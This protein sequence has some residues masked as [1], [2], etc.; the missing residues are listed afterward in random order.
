MKNIRFINETLSHLGFGR[1]QTE[2]YLGLLKTGPATITDLARALNTSRQALYLLLPDLLDRGLVKEVKQ[3]KRPYYQALAPSQLLTL[4]EDLKTRVEEIVPSL[5]NIQA[6]PAE[7]PLVT[8]YDTPLS[9]REWYRYFMENAQAGEEFY[10]Y[11]SG[12]LAHWFKQ[13]EK[14]YQEYLESQIRIGV[15]VFC[16]LPGKNRTTEE[17]NQEVGWSVTEF[18]YTDEPLTTNV[19]QWVWRDQV[20][21]QTI[22][23]NSTNMILLQS[24]Q[25]ANLAKKQFLRIWEVSE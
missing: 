17:H 2:A 9:M 14:F 15:K 8:V 19:H 5:T 16:L 6:I 10:L 12:N 18:R 25:L 20:C 22:Q 3:G 13:D 4:V 23:E 1:N 24:E 21:Y 7:V 11:S